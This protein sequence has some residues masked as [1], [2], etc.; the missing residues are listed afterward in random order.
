MKA[1]AYARVSS[2]GQE[3]GD[4]L[5]RQT[6][7]I[8]SYADE[9]GM[10]LVGKYFRESE[11]GTSDFEDRPVFMDMIRY[12]IENEVGIIIVEG[13][14]RI[15]R[16]MRVQEALL[17]YLV[18]KNLTLISVRTG[19]DV[20]EAVSRDPMRKALIQIQGVFAELEKGMLVQKLRKA[21]T[22]IKL[23]T[24]RCEGR[25][26]YGFYKAEDPVLDDIIQSWRGGESYAGIARSLNMR[27]IRTRSGG[28]WTPT[29]ISRIMRREEG[30]K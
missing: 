12:C 18:S 24:G 6:R 2:V 26:P 23:T 22:Q 17:I 5:D 21:R 10:T 7:E 16:E 14:D 30:A 13:L 20:T 4:G 19:E 3:K 1:V 11:S 15:A 29:T 28:R 27:G 9:Q 8:Q 25:K